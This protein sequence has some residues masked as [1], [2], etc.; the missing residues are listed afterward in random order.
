VYFVFPKVSTQPYQTSSTALVHLLLGWISKEAAVLGCRGVISSWS[1]V[2]L[3][4]SDL[5]SSVFHQ[6]FAIIPGREWTAVGSWRWI[7]VAVS[8]WWYPLWL[9]VRRACG[10]ILWA[11]WTCFV[12]HGYVCLLLM[13]TFSDFLDVTVF[14][15]F[16]D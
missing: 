15:E 13:G 3:G 1:I 10:K 8:W 7:A 14:C 11:F 4:T 5:L 6:T 12:F 9:A 16:D 2:S